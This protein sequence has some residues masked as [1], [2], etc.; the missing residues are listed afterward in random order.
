MKLLQKKRFSLKI[1]EVSDWYQRSRSIFLTNLRSLRKGI[2]PN[3][4]IISFFRNP[5]TNFELIS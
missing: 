3:L 4:N 5:L 1:V 2:Y